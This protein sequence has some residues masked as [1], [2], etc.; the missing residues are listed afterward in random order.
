[1]QKSKPLK[2]RFTVEENETIDACIDMMK[3]EGY[4]PIR[5]IEEPVFKEIIT[6]IDGLRDIQPCGRKIVFEGKLEKPERW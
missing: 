6:E 2:I 5:R 4:L 1:M 3:N